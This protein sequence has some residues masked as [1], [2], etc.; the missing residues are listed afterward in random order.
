MAIWR[1]FA[2][3]L[4]RFPTG[5]YISDLHLGG[6]ITPQV[7][8]F[9]L[10]LS[11]FVRGRVYLHFEHA[12]DAEASLAEAGFASAQV[13]PAADSAGV[14]HDRGSRLAHILEASTR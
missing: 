5:R 13:E 8:A 3:A 4:N 1:R 2:G 11:A 10:L 7:R 6:A 9:R 14:E 12:G